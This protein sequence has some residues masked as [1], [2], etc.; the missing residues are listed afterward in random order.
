MSSSDILM[1]APIILIELGL[2][3]AAMVDLV[4]REKVTGGNKLLW[5]AVV[6]FVGII[7]PIVYFVFG[8]KE[9]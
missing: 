7:G 5:G 9:D 8:R 2:A 4:K 3:I 1:L 6:L